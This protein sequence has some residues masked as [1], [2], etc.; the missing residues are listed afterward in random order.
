MRVLVTGGT[1]LLGWWVARKLRERGYKVYAT[2][3][4]LEP[5]ELED[6]EWV[7]MDLSDPGSVRE[8]LE[9][10]RPDAVVHS[11]AY[12]DVDG[13]ERDRERAYRVNYLGTRA[14]AW[15]ARRL[16]TH[17]VY[18]STDYV[19]DGERGMY[20]EEDTP[21]PVNYYGFTKLLGEVAVKS[22][23]EGMGCIVRVSGLY[24]CSPTGKRN[25]GIGALEALLDGR[26]VRAFHDQYLSPT[27]VPRLAESIAMLVERGMTGVIHVAGERLSR[28]QFALLLA[29]ELGAD[30]GLVK[31]VPMSSVRLVARRPRDSSLDTTRAARMGLGLPPARECIRDFVE[32]CRELATGNQ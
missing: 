21:A 2:Y 30:R 10:A 3:H 22:I 19:F 23:L 8:A 26:E 32:T 18:V 27:Y 20:R 4:V 9:L 24:G 16:G 25:F 1:G 6:V 7:M 17:V 13:C 5:S 31:P 29:E 28:Y 12:T 15:V 11:A 14:L